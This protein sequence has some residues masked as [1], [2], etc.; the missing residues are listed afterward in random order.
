MLGE[1][2]NVFLRGIVVGN[3]LMSLQMKVAA[4]THVVV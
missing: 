1:A 4:I 2:V 3:K